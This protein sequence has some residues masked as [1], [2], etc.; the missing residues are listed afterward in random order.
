VV[1]FLIPYSDTF[2][3]VFTWETNFWTEPAKDE[4]EI[5]YDSGSGG[6]SMPVTLKD[7][8]TGEVVTTIT[9]QM[10][11]STQEVT[12]FHEVRWVA[13]DCYDD[14]TYTYE[15]QSGL[16]TITESYAPSGRNTKIVFDDC[17]QS[18]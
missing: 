7:T 9:Y 2:D 6:E 3:W 16:G 4:V 5:F 8:G 15:V 12:Y 17:P 14:C 18:L 1:G 13:R 10:D 11:S